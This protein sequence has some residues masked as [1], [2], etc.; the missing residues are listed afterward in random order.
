MRSPKL[1][2]SCLVAG[3]L[4]GLSPVVFADDAATAAEP[5]HKAGKEMH[6][7]KQH[8][9]KEMHEKKKEM[10]DKKQDM[11]QEM[12]KNMKGKMKKESMNTYNPDSTDTTED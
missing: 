5:A 9:K 11:K 7:K 1:T 6:E 4:F 3:L 2:Y 12:H 10:H 8:M